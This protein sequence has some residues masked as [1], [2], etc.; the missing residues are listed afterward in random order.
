LYG[1][2]L[3]LFLVLLKVVENENCV[4]RTRRFTDEYPRADWKGRSDWITGWVA[5]VRGQTQ[6]QSARKS[7][8]ADGPAACASGR[9]RTERGHWNASAD[10][11]QIPVHILLVLLL[12]MFVVR[13]T[14][15][16]F[17]IILIGRCVKRKKKNSALSKPKRNATATSVDGSVKFAFFRC[18][19]CEPFSGGSK[20]R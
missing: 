3:P 2:A 19:C 14:S 18:T 16:E 1:F 8:H 13:M 20:Y 17:R 12:R 7:Q 9:R 15:I 11:S 4:T 5:T 10:C 6:V